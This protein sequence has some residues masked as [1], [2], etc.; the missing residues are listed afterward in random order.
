MSTTSQIVETHRQDSIVNSASDGD[1]T[2]VTEDRSSENN[3]SNTT[4]D[5]IVILKLIT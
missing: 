2:N 4:L 5:Q 1:N 3:R